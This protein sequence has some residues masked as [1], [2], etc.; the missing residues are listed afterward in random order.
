[1]GTLA[2]LAGT[3]AGPQGR[4]PAGNAE[5]NPSSSAQP[6]RGLVCVIVIASSI[7]PSCGD[8][9]PA[10][11]EKRIQTKATS[12]A[13]GWGV[14]TTSGRKGVAEIRI[15]GE[16][17]SLTSVGDVEVADDGTIA[18]IQYEDRAIRF[19]D[20][21]GA[22]RGKFGRSG[23]GPGEFQNPQRIGWHGDT[24][25]V[26][27]PQLSRVTYYSKRSK[28]DSVRTVL[29]AELQ[30]GSA[31]TP[32]LGVA[33]VH[34]VTP[35]GDL[36]VWGSTR[37]ASPKPFENRRIIIRVS[38]GGAAKHVISWLPAETKGRS[39]SFS[40]NSVSGVPMPFF[41]RAIFD[42]SPDGSRIAVA[43]GITDGDSAGTFWVN[44][45]NADGDTVF[46]RTF[47]IQL[48]P[49]TAHTADSVRSDYTKQASGPNMSPERAAAFKQVEIPAFYNPLLMLL[50]NNDG[51]VWIRFRSSRDDVA[52]RWLALSD[53][54]E[55]VDT[56]VFPVRSR[57]RFF[58]ND[59][60]WV[61][62]PDELDVPHLVKYR[63]K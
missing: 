59:V 56:L 2:A 20:P 33:G 40:P 46:N 19:F 58:S 6:A 11:K 15:D 10:S 35:N 1:M 51:T 13:T 26:W 61:V 57:P 4:N 23:S 22:D 60:L 37:A 49:I 25:W 7:L 14:S 42:L 30:D 52:H 17:M 3:V 8:Q 5:R 36:L 18:V 50:V 28:R 31:G 43:E 34:A 29:P 24:L 45:L 41:S 21:A 54:G 38:R 47:P 62:E 16:A 12:P 27:D 9:V 44:L 53:R 55:P 39:V 63:L 32:A 48:L